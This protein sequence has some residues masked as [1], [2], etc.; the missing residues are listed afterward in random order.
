MAW[1]E[2]NESE[3]AREITS[4]PWVEDGI[5]ASERNAVQGL[6]HLATFGKSAFDVI[7]GSEWMSEGLSEAEVSVVDILAYISSEE[8]PDLARVIASL[9]W[10]V[11][12]VDEAEAAALVHLG[13]IGLYSPELA[14]EVLAFQWVVDSIREFEAK[15]IDGLGL[16]AKNN[17][18][19]A[20][21]TVSLS[22]VMDGVDESEADIVF[23]LGWAGE[24][25]SALVGTIL[26]LPWVQDD[27]DTLE[28]SV[29]QGLERIARNHPAQA[30]Q[31]AGMPFLARLGPA[32]NLALKSLG[33]LSLFR[34]DSFQRIMKHPKISA[35]ISDDWAK[36]V[37]TLY[38][39]DKNNPQLV[40]ALL[41]S[42]RVSLEERSIRLPLVG[43]IEL[44]II[45]LGPGAVRSMNLLEHAV[46]NA[47]TFIDAP[48][49]T[50][51]AALLF[52]DGVTE[53][54][55]GTNFGTHMAI[56]PEYDVDDGSHEAQ[57]AAAI[58]A[59]EVA[60]YY[61]SGNLAWIDEGAS[62]FIAAISES[63]RV[64][65]PLEPENAPCGYAENIATIER[66]GASGEDKTHSAFGCNYSL[67]ERIFLD[68]YRSLGEDQF[69]Q[70]FRFLYEASKME[71]ETDE[72]TE[73]TAVGI[74]ELRRAFGHSTF[75]PT[76]TARWYEG[77]ESYDRSGLDKN[78]VISSLPS[79]TGSVD[80]V[81]VALS[82][83]DCYASRY[84]LNFSVSEIIDWAFICLNYSYSVPTSIGSVEVPLEYATYYEDGFAFERRALAFTAESKYIGGSWSFATGPPAS[85]PWAPGRYYVYVYHEEVKVGEAEFM[86]LP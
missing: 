68:L 27:M 18:D 55:A 54:F 47:E 84:E 52:A 15:A 14:D 29:I 20:L 6:V 37:A 13:W 43:D 62:E 36:I 25:S 38:G 1:L 78:P 26:S 60:H 48:F 61:W 74:A 76:V 30:L 39:V 45:R 32:D 83:E 57:S 23:D 69:Q 24:H 5:E 4:L 58:I 44:A 72:T 9:S 81:K 3:L 28:A 50:K 80:P 41:D 70:G 67:G 33:W 64:A 10:V 85:E 12:G 40:D 11:D 2:Q 63:T 79:V 59:H 73:G 77:T 42:E 22:W 46:R 31:I 86:V 8:L 75:T 49:P 34:A 66:L 17:P 21:T 82:A 65:R 56:L 71:D 16:A 19:H 35:G 53:S 51:Y 7:I